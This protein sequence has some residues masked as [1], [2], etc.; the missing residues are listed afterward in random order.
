MS[1]SP[2]L[3]T[4]IARSFGSLKSERA[5]PA[6]EH[7][8]ETGHVSEEGEKDPHPKDK[9]RTR[10]GPGGP[11]VPLRPK[12]T[13]PLENYYLKYSWEYF[14]QKI[15]ITYSFIVDT[16]NILGNFL[17]FVCAETD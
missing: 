2:G 13:M 8:H 1:N 17:V 11:S 12:I 4:S 15:C 3:R 7:T 5:Y 16:P 9:F 6:L 14:M 10:A